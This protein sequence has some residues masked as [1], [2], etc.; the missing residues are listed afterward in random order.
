[1]SL[2]TEPLMTARSRAGSTIA[3]AQ[4]EPIDESISYQTLFIRS[5][6]EFSAVIFQLICFSRLGA[7]DYYYLV[8]QNADFA[9]YDN[10]QLEPSLAANFVL[11][12]TLLIF[13][14][15]YLNG[16][17]LFMYDTCVVGRS[18]LQRKGSCLILTGIQIIAVV[19]VW[20]IIRAAQEHW[21]GTITWIVPQVQ[22]TDDGRAWWAEFVEEWF[23]VMALL[24]GYIHLTYLNFEP[25]FC[26]SKHT[27]SDFS[28]EVLDYAIPLPFIMQ[29]TLLVAGLLRAFP[30]SHMSPHISCYIMAMGYTTW[31]A[32]FLRM[33]GGVAGYISAYLWYW[34]SY[35]PRHSK[36]SSKYPTYK[37]GKTI[38]TM[39]QK[40][41]TKNEAF[42]NN[43]F[44]I[45]FQNTPR[46]YTR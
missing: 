46:H 37:Y 22:A 26:S 36:L 19:V 28:P 21:K 15:P 24:V 4:A 29:I 12:V 44:A 16:Y 17:I 3:Q 5:V 8:N 35:V 6:T 30:T 14:F 38:I 27:F 42:L 25:L 32:F 13:Q 11:F 40:V 33:A 7:K 31:P 45:S 39:Y 34:Y 41:P 23:A 2:D 43:T 1:M 20:S 18:S 10:S 9:R